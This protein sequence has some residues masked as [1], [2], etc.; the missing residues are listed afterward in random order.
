LL[1]CRDIKRQL[2]ALCEA[3]PYRRPRPTVAELTTK[4]W[5]IVSSSHARPLPA[6]LNSG[7]FWTGPAG[8]IKRPGRIV[9]EFLQPIP[10]GLKRAEFMIAL[11]ERIETTTARLVAEGR[12]QTQTAR[13]ALPQK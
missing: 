11:Q 10:A 3:R 9:L 13:S 1:H 7:L 12:R 5:E 6:A 8:F 2:L 4:L